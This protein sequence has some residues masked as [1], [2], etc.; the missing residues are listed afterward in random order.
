MRSEAANREF[1]LLALFAY[2]SFATTRRDILHYFFYFLAPFVKLERGDFD[3]KVG[4]GEK[5]EK[6][7]SA[8]EEFVKVGLDKV[9]IV[10][11]RA[12]PVDKN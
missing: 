11:F 2:V 3:G 8:G 4:L 7:I 9:G 10:K 1:A 12:L 5:V 6:A